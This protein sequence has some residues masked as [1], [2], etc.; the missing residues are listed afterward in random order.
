ML[1]ILHIHFVPDSSLRPLLSCAAAVVKNPLPWSGE[2]V[3]LTLKSAVN[4]LCSCVWFACSL[5]SR[6]P[7]SSGWLASHSLSLF[8][9]RLLQSSFHP[10]SSCHIEWLF[11]LFSVWSQQTCVRH[12]CFQLDF[13]ALLPSKLPPRFD[14]VFPCC[15]HDIILS[16]RRCADSI[17]VPSA[18]LLLSETGMAAQDVSLEEDT[19]GHTTGFCL[20]KF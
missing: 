14:S 20:V 16:I 13:W 4:A 3:W 5:L 10:S 12:P 2:I 18:C 8:H 6:D 7:V 1:P 17:P 19:G 15:G 11:I 9:Q